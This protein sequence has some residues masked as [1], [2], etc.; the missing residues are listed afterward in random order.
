MHF[1]LDILTL[2]FYLIT[3]GRMPKGR[4]DEQFEINEKAWNTVKNETGNILHRGFIERQYLLKDFRYGRSRALSRKLF[5]SGKELT[6]ADNSCEVIAA[7]NAVHDINL[8]KKAQDRYSF[9]ELIRIFSEKGIAAGGIFGTSPVI[10]K[11]VLK[12]LGY[13]VKSL[14]PAALRKANVDKLEKEYDSFIFTTYNVRY[15]PVRMIHTMCVSREKSGFMIH[16][17]YEGSLSYKSLYGAVTGYKGGVGHP[18]YLIG[19]KEKEN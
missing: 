15:N 14:S 18:F 17:D 19:I 5:F 11:K 8:K 13:S 9:P 1:L 3:T 16:N 12:D 2:L 4:A 7:F 10:I 6:A